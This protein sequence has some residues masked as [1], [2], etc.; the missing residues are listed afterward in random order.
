MMKMVG[1]VLWYPEMGEKA[2][3]GAEIVS[4]LS[5]YGTHMFLKT[6]LE[7]SGRGIVKI[8]DRL[9]RATKLAYKKICREH[10]VSSPL[11]MN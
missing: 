6:D 3:E 5:Y 4:E 1:E 11:Y 7:L 10:L 8:G 2:P 9:Y